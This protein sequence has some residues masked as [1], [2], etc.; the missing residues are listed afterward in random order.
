MLDTSNVILFIP[1]T[2][3]ILVEFVFRLN[4]PN[5]K[6]RPSHVINVFAAIF[7]NWC[8]AIG[9]HLAFLFDYMTYYHF[10]KNIF[11]NFFQFL[12]K[13]LLKLDHY[14]KLFGKFLRKLIRQLDYYLNLIIQKIFVYTPLQDMI[15]LLKAAIKFFASLGKFFDGYGE[16]YHKL[17]QGKIRK[18]IA[19]SLSLSILFLSAIYFFRFSIAIFIE[20]HQDT[21]VVLG[22][23]FVHLLP[24]LPFIVF[25][26]CIGLPLLNYNVNVW[27]K[28]HP[29]LSLPHH[30]PM[31]S[32]IVYHHG[33]RDHYQHIFRGFLI[34]FPF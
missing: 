14:F 25:P 2:I 18:A 16:Y 6:L 34:V 30:I 13:I 24:C 31:N 10:L 21:L 12:N 3:L 5:S 4:Y 33:V 23:I 17:L 19:L 28:F 29:L 26:C 9:Q 8:F 22:M 15:S 32:M 11:N 7:G 20:M 1:V 27:I